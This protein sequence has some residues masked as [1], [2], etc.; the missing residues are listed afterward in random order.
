MLKKILYLVCFLLISYINSVSAFPN[1]P[2]GFRNLYWGE[3]L[4][5][6]KNNGYNVKYGSYYPVENAVIYT[7]PL[8]HTR[9][10]SVSLSNA[11]LYLSLWN[12][13]LY[14]I[15]IVEDCFDETDMNLRYDM[16]KKSMTNH[17]GYSTHETPDMSCSWTGNV[18]KIHLMKMTSWGKS[19]LF[20]TIENIDLLTK[21][22]KDA[23]AQGW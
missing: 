19:N 9:L 13:Q 18:T 1:E 17:F 4:Q 20:I 3:T 7:M 14:K 6:I 5:E 2:N 23:D 16:L 21:A 15:V 12:N 11:D 10:G 8:S 22:K